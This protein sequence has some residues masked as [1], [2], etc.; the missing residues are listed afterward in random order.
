MTDT[1]QLEPVFCY[2]GKPTGKLRPV[3]TQPPP[4]TPREQCPSCTAVAG[5][6]PDSPGGGTGECPNC[7]ETAID[8]VARER[9]YHSG[10]IENMTLVIGDRMDSDSFEIDEVSCIGCGHPR[11]YDQMDYM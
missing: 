1:A 11:D 5:I 9:V 2:C 6:N 7:G 3:G 10:H 4:F 8:V